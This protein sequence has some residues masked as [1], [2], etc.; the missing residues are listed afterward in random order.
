M[1]LGVRIVAIGSLVGLAIVLF[2][3]LVRRP[4]F[5]WRTL[6]R[7]LVWAGVLSA[8]GLANTIPYLFRQYTTETPIAL[9]RLGL[10]VSML[11]GL[12][13]ILLV[14]GVGFA[15][16]EGARPGWA[17]ALRRGTGV[18]DALK[19]AAIAAAG[20][21]GLSHWFHVISSRVPAL[22]EPDPSLP[23]SLQYAIPAVDVLWV[24]G[25]GAFAIAAI[26]AVGAIALQS[27]FFRAPL[28]RAVLAFSLLVA[29]LPSDFHS[30]GRFAARAAA[31]PA[32]V[33]VARPLGGVPAAGQ[34]RGVGPLRPPRIRRPRRP[35]DRGPALPG[36]SRRGLALD[37]ASRRRRGSA[38]RGR[39]E[40]G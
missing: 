6:V 33:R 30:A 31:G 3:R 27:Q 2:L 25:R 18:G 36:G 14:S 37:A 23:G 7:P 24:A 15:V 17:Q 1:L 29:L 12:L 39:A 38:P 11:I 13:G 32:A 10:G 9:F 8:A 4:G 28:G 40:A 20:V 35:G 19:R 16:Y 5:H 22:Y 21:A 34:R 26:A